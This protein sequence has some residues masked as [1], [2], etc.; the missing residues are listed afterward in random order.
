MVIQKGLKDVKPI[1][2]QLRPTEL[3]P[4]SDYPLLHY[5]GLVDVEQL[6]PSA[7]S[8]IFE[9]N[10]WETQWIMRYAPTQ[11]AHYHS[12]THET[13]VVLNGQARIRFGAADLTSG[14]DPSEAHEDG[15]VEI[16]AASGDVF[17]IPAGVSHKTF[18]TTPQSTRISF[19][20]LTPGDGH[21]I[22]NADLDKI[23]LS[24]YIML[25]AYP[26]GSSE[27]DFCVG[28]EGKTEPP[29]PSKDPVLGESQDGLL[30]IWK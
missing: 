10:G 12:K 30:G 3:T 5:R 2:Y 25:G 27:W 23:D 26:R 20:V 4:N 14:E 29:R 22:G 28:G 17:V 18:N 16:D 15:G 1:A 24:G 21:S 8:K 19:E 13:M 9:D 11:R 6:T 7:T